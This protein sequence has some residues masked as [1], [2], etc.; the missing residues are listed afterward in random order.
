[1]ERLDLPEA[2][3]RASPALWAS[4]PAA[5]DFHTIKN[6]PPSRGSIALQARE[7]GPLPETGREQPARSDGRL[8]VR[9]VENYLVPGGLRERPQTAL[10]CLSISIRKILSWDYAPPRRWDRRA[11]A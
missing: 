5:A 6:G 7:A 1:M 2:V 4:F 8:K 9:F 3:T 10:S 11:A